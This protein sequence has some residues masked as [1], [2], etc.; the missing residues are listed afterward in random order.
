MLPKWSL[1]GKESRPTTCMSPSKLTTAILRSKANLK[2]PLT[3]GHF[4][5]ASFVEK[6]HQP[7]KGNFPLVILRVDEIAQAQINGLFREEI[8]IVT[9]CHRSSPI[10]THAALL[11]TGAAN[12]KESLHFLF[13]ISDLFLKK[14]YLE[15]I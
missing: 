10:R 6:G 11:E 15:E 7:K 3:K 2:R 13:R 9:F 14:P 12:Q 8:G 1:P 5:L 4:P